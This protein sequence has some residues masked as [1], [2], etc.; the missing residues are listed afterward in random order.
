VLGLPSAVTTSAI[1]DAGFYR[2]V[3]SATDQFFT[4]PRISSQK[5]AQEIH[6]G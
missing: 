2:R 5:S 3:T 1:D 6:L 4:F